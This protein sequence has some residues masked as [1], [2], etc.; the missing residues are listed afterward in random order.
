[1]ELADG[2]SW[3]NFEKIV[4]DGYYVWCAK[5]TQIKRIHVKMLDGVKEGGEPE[6][7]VAFG[8][9]S[10]TAL[11][12]FPLSLDGTITKQ[13][14][15][16]RRKISLKQF[17]VNCANARTVHK[18]QGR[19]IENLVISAFDY[20]DNWIYVA[21]SRVCTM[22]GLFLRLPLEHKKTKGMSEDCKAFHKLFR[23]T[24]QPP[25]RVEIF[26]EDV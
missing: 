8:T 4:I 12:E 21:L 16:L 26:R 25:K 14:P 17:P 10:T 22:K 2:V 7:I 6:K 19:S 24:K 20:T 5:V 23:D 13:T 11:C 9:V 1:M 15:R 3:D 18:L